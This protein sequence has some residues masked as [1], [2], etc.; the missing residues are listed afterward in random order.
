MGSY[1]NTG[2]FALEQLWLLERT[3]LCFCAP[4]SRWFKVVV[5]QLEKDDVMY[6]H[7]VIRV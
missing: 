7:A 5:T 4:S 3:D 2:C 1:I 6:F